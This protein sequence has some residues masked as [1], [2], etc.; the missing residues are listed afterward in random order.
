MIS[1]EFYERF[2]LEA[3]DSTTCF[4][5]IRIEAGKTFKLNSDIKLLVNE[6]AKINLFRLYS[7]AVGIAHVDSFLLLTST[8]FVRFWLMC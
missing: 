3:F 4:D 1:I 6:N 7:H 5:Q 2:A 8:S